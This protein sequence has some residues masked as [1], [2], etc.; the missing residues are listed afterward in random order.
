VLIETCTKLAKTCYNIHTMNNATVERKS[1]HITLDSA[2]NRRLK[3]YTSAKYVQ[4]SRVASAIFK[5]ALDEFLSRNG[6]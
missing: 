1:Y 5:K 2:L 3:E 4:N 6:Y